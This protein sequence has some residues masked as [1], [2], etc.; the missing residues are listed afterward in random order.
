V[1]FVMR[2]PLVSTVSRLRIVRELNGVDTFPPAESGWPALAEQVALC[3]Q[4]AV[5]YV[6]VD[7][8]DLRRDPGGMAR[9]LLARLGLP[10]ESGLH[11]WAPRP[12][13]RLAAPGVGELMGDL[14]ATDDPFYRRVLGSAGI[15][16]AEHVDREVARAAVTRAGLAAEVERW[17]VTYHR[18][19][20][21]P[22]RLAPEH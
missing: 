21:D 19:R 13:L 11:R 8:T 15:Q 2:D 22:G 10:D 14:R 5:P 17:Q 9:A 7:S 12:G 4:T 3:R 18:L 20:A 6:I 16:P 1:V